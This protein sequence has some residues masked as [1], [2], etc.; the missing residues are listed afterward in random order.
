MQSPSCVGEGVNKVLGETRLS[1]V[2]RGGRE[3]GQEKK[4]GAEKAGQPNFFSAYITWVGTHAIHHIHHY[5]GCRPPPLV[6]IALLLLSTRG[7]I[8]KLVGR[9]A[10]WTKQPSF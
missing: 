4:G 1:G 2:E 3:R 5:I 8:F 7:C 9:Q 6:L 10:S